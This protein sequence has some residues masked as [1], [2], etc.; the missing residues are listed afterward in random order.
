MSSRMAGSALLRQLGPRLFA[1]SSAAAAP[2]EPSYTVLLTGSAGP[3]TAKSP[4]A[5]LVR[6]FPARMASTT[7][8]KPAV[9]GEEESEPLK[10]AP[11]PEASD[12]P[13]SERKAI[14]SYWDINPNKIVKQDGTEWKWSCFMVT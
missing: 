7:A 9:G 8:A 10:S 4:V 1:V 6:L 5:A 12:T 3:A 13:P 11:E 2:V 14:T